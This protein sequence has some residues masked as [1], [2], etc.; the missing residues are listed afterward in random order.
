[1]EITSNCIVNEAFLLLW[2]TPG[3][4]LEYHVII[5]PERHG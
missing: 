1:M 3:L 2:L 4:V 5:P